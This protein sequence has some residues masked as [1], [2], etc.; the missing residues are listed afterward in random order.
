MKFADRLAQALKQKGITSNALSQRL[1]ISSTAV[2]NWMHG[3]TKPRPEMLER[4][5]TELGTDLAWL[6]GADA[7]DAQP[8][9]IE[10]LEHP[11]TIA[12]ILAEA[13]A[14]LT[15]HLK[16]PFSLELKLIA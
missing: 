4:I 2:W 6:R 9:Q 10:E 5:A 11:E 8:A 1:G 15:P 7:V 12:G 16:A 13:R 3:N 14:R